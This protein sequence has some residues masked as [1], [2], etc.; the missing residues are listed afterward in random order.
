MAAVPPRRLP[1]RSHSV[2]AAP[3]SQ[4]VRENRSCPAASMAST[5]RQYAIPVRSP[6]SSFICRESTAAT[7]LA[8][9]SPRP[10]LAAV[11]AAQP[12]CA[13]LDGQV[14]LARQQV[15]VAQVDVEGNEAALVADPAQAFL[16]GG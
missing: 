2:S 11:Q 16:R 10:A 13:P 1:V 3:S 8:S 5:S 9:V 7:A 14:R 15:Q 6:T 12:L 4:A